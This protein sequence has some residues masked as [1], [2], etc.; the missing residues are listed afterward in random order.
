MANMKQVFI[1][2]TAIFLIWACSTQK[3][4]VKVEKNQTVA[5]A[6]SVEYDIEMFDS[7]FETWYIMHKNPSLNRSL[8]YYENWNKKYVKAWNHK[9]LKMGKDSFF[10]PI[11]G[12]HSNE[13]YSFEL[14]HKLFYYF[15]Y[16]ENVLKIEIMP[17]G[18][19]DVAGY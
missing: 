18:P 7:K 15:Q 19:K 9:S 14:N 6:D 5:K 12:Y 16:V 17:G 11:V 1:F 8:N 2:F 4:T 13:D 3:A 10:S